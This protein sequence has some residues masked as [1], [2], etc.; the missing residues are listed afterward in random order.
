M[1]GQR[2]RRC[3]LGE[4]E[5]EVP[6]GSVLCRE[7]RGAPSSCPRGLRGFVQGVAQDSE[8]PEGPECPRTPF[9][10]RLLRHPPGCQGRLLASGPHPAHPAELTARCSG[11]FSILR[12]ARHLL[13]P[14]RPQLWDGAWGCPP[15]PP[16]RSRASRRV[17]GV[18]LPNRG[19][20]S[21]LGSLSQ[22]TAPRPAGPLRP[23]P[24]S[25]HDRGCIQGP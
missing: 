10:P 25:P 16:E 23:Y 8:S 21:A 9:F 4:E 13:S 2:T 5:E 14:A 20:R 3:P 6:R 17:P 19:G 18:S 1:R 7:C 22:G 15:R 24:S 11:T 12:P